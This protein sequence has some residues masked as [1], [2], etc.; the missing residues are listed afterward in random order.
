MLRKSTLLPNSDLKSPGVTTPLFVLLIVVF[1]L[2]TLRCLYLQYFQSEHYYSLSINQQAQKPQ[3]G[4]I[5]DS[6]GRLLAGS[7]RVWTIFAE[8]RVIKDP[9]AVS[10]ELVSIVDM[11]GHQIH[12]LITESKNPGF[13]KIKTGAEADQCDAAVKIYGIGVQ[14]DWQRH[15]PAGALAGHVVGFTSTDNR[16]LA[17]IE[18]QY[19][20]EL[21]GSVG[22]NVFLADVR[23]RPLRL[24]Q[25]NSILKDGTGVILT[26]DS[27]IQQFTRGELLKQFESYEAESAVAIVAEPKT[28]AIL[29]MVS[30]PD[31]IPGQVQSSDPNNLRNRSVTD[32]FEPGSIIKPIV[33]AIAIDC[34]TVN[35]DEKIFCE[36]GNYRGR[37]FGRIHEYRDHG[38]G[39]LAI[40]EILIKS[41]NIGMAKIG[42]KM[43]KKKLYRGLS[44]FGFGKKTGIDL[45][46]EAE[47]LLRPVGKWT[48]YSVTRIPYG[49]EISATALQIVRAYCILANGGRPVRLHLAK[50][51]VDSD[52]KV[53]KL[54][55]PPPAVGFI[56]KPEVAKWIITNPL[57]GVVNERQN[58]GTGWR[59]RLKKWQVFGKTGTANTAKIGERGYEENANIASFIAG[60]PVDDPAVVVLVSVCKP[61]RKLG[62]GDSGGPVASPVAARI[63]EKTL[64][65]LGVP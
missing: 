52:G 50:A 37:G 63:I 16:G 29:A 28:G 40:R 15:Y 49:Y 48:G 58:G 20:K 2:L 54:Q 62:K 25:Q 18:L 33:A 12:R 45:P 53:T 42:Q 6:R 11:D 46:G 26:I 14:S 13:A 27:A 47:G 5:L 38:Y 56:I 32:Q 41:S 55:R 44:L 8:P 1:L 34:G 9:K 59:A 10:A 19:N 65:Y 22:Q 61:N 21:C 60:A 57:V 23:R 64:T 17:G 39:N 43:G 7:N 36:N 24:K 35:T 30:L 31:F 3:R 4:V 51:M